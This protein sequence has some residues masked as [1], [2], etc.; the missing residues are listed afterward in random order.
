MNQIDPRVAVGQ[1][2]SNCA[3]GMCGW[4]A[5]DYPAY[6]AQDPQMVQWIM[7]NG[8]NGYPAGLQNV[9][10]QAG[11]NAWLAAQQAANQGYCG[12]Y[13]RKQG[14]RRTVLGLV[15]TVMGANAAGVLCQISVQQPFTGHALRIPSDI[16]ATLLINDIKVGTISQIVAGP[17]PARLFDELSLNSYLDMDTAQTSQVITISF[18]NTGA[19][20]FTV[21]GEFEGTTVTC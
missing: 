10:G 15:P 5:Q 6:F 7:Q 21:Y 17:L 3:N 11:A 18:T 19:G 14:P 16:V 12:P 8:S 9:Q 13:G 4:V 2:G 1:L 20:Q